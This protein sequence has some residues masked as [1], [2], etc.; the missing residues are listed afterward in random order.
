M[1]L[2]LWEHWAWAHEFGH[3]RGLRHVRPSEEPKSFAFNLLRTPGI[4]P[5]IQTQLSDRQCKV[6]REGPPPRVTKKTGGV[7][8]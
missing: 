8:R 7:N 2:K 6:I 5:A 1:K 3:T 4:D